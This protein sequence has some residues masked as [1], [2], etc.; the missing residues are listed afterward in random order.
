M[1][2]RISLAIIAFLLLASMVNGQSNN[3]LKIDDDIQLIHLQDSVFIHV[4]WHSLEGFGRFSSNGM[5][6]IQD[7]KAVLVDTP[8]DNDKT[9]RLIQFVK[10]SLHAG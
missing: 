9:E 7:G 6:I 4:S 8:M 1:P 3:I 10:N 5:I 2:G